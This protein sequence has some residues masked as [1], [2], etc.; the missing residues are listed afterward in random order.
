MSKRV[1]RRFALVA[2]VA[3]LTAGLSAPAAWAGAPGVTLV[4]DAYH[5]REWA[6]GRH[7]VNYIEWWYFNLFD[8][9]QNLQAVSDAAHGRRGFDS[10][11][12]CPAL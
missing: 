2:A 12:A 5:Y 7:D 3:L 10:R 9:E 8:A 4:D 11:K 1:A 6:N